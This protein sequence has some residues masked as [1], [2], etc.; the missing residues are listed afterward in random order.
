MGGMARFC[1]SFAMTA[2]MLSAAAT[3]LGVQARDAEAS[4]GPTGRGRRKFL[5]RLGAVGASLALP[6]IVS[7]SAGRGEQGRRLPVAPGALSGF[8]SS[9]SP[10]AAFARG[11]KDVVEEALYG[12][13]TFAPDAKL[14]PLRPAGAP[15]CRVFARIML[16][17]GDELAHSPVL[18]AATRGTP[19]AAPE[20]WSGMPIV[21]L[22]QWALSPL[23]VQLGRQRAE[24]EQALHQ[25][26]AP[27]ELRIAQAVAGVRDP[28]NV[29]L[30]H[31]H[32][33]VSVNL[34]WLLEATK[35]FDA[36]GVHAFLTRG[37]LADWLFGAVPTMMAERPTASETRHAWR[38]VAGRPNAGPQSLAR[39]AALLRLAEQRFGS[40]QAGS[41][42]TPREVADFLQARAA[43]GWPIS[44][45]LLREALLLPGAGRKLALPEEELFFDDGFLEGHEPQVQD[46]EEPPE[47]APGPGREREGGLASRRAAG[48]SGG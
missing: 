3:V 5:A 2:L 46:E 18:R 35:V 11:W 44:F 17:R 41:A 33:D 39:H 38:E 32:W 34:D 4:A 42:Q 36:P 12:L 20:S 48:A 28:D 37:L 43:G 1:K 10:G 13:E 47:Q 19:H 26:R 7:A 40:D 15:L 31:G 8:V 27:Q 21:T 23:G 16:V 22:G 29:A 9:Y 45:H 30:I 14:N 6:R 24:I 25:G